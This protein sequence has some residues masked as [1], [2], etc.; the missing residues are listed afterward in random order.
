MSYC[1]FSGGSDIYLFHHVGGFIQC[2]GC[3]MAEG[4][5]IST[6]LAT[7]EDALAHIAKHRENGDSVPTYVDERL[8]KEI[9][10]GEPLEA[11]KCDY[12][13][14]TGSDAPVLHSF[15]DPIGSFCSGECLEKAREDQKECPSD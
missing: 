11:S 7:R 9:E 2:C 12:C 6:N 4:D 3:N 10:D 5:S 13:G 15:A 14:A 8:R 1:R